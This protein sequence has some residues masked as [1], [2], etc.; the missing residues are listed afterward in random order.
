MN[1]DYRKAREA[2]KRD[3]EDRGWDL[4][5]TY[6]CPNCS[7]ASWDSTCCSE[8]GAYIGHFD[9]NDIE[10]G[11]W[12]FQP[13]RPGRCTFNLA[14]FARED[15][16]QAVFRVHRKYFADIEAKYESGVAEVR[17]RDM[18]YEQ[19][20]AILSERWGISETELSERVKFQPNDPE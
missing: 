7:Q 12:V 6:P 8:C 5:E 10:P 14:E 15:I 13:P 3:L 18:N 4:S 1:E 11:D 20:I 16:E 2:Q 9:R 17:C 19:L